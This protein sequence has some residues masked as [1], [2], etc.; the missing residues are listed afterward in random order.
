MVNDSFFNLMLSDLNS[1]LVK[2]TVNG[3]EEK[4]LA[5]L[6]ITY[7]VLRRLGF[8]EDRVEECIRAINGVDLE[9][10][11]DWVRRNISSRLCKH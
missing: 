6:A 7:G 10:A 1:V 3:T 5:R 9:E 4:A 11:A 2:T 8:Q